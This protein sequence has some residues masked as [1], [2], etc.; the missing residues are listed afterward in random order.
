MKYW[1]CLLL[2]FLIPYSCLQVILNMTWCIIFLFKLE[3]FVPLSKILAY[4]ML[5]DEEDILF[6]FLLKAFIV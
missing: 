3:L 4:C 5:H 1:E 6:C 2:L